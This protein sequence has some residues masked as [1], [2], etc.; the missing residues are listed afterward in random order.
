MPLILVLGFL[1]F[2]LLNHLR[3]E[4]T[5]NPQYGYGWAV[6][7]LCLY[8]LW[9]RLKSPISHLP[10]ST[11]HLPPPI[12][13]LLLCALAFLYAPTRLTQE[14]N[15]DWR[16]ISWALAIEVVGLTFLLAQTQSTIYQHVTHNAKH[17]TRP[18]FSSPFF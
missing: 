9:R 6:P 4:W 11:S 17:E 2:T 15:P 18:I 14:A 12:F 1:W 10:S 5:V 13:Y 8:L 3:V 7:F 16:L